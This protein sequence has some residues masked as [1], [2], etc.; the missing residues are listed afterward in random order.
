MKLSNLW[1]FF[2]SGS[3]TNTGA[4]NLNQITA[5]GVGTTTVITEAQHLPF[6]IIP[7][8]GERWIPQW[9]HKFAPI[10]G[11]GYATLS[12]VKSQGNGRTTKLRQ[13][14]NPLRQVS[15]IIIPPRT[16]GIGKAKLFHIKAKGYGFHSRELL[17]EEELLILM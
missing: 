9:G 11:V 2:F 3:R 10:I 8:R 15:E 5:S 13:W 1:L 4:A 14:W 17:D 7:P 6:G 16:F 12:R